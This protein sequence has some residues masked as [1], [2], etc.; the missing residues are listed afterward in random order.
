[1]TPRPNTSSA[2][3]K[4]LNATVQRT[5]VGAGASARVKSREC[6]GKRCSKTFKPGTVRRNRFWLRRS[7]R[8]NVTDK[9]QMKTP[10]S[11]KTAEWV[12]LSSAA[13]TPPSAKM[14]KMTKKLNDF[15][16]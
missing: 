5:T 16:R 1:M 12:F 13:K 8:K 9:R 11:R 3:N 2:P 4:M 15:K 14:E 10:I 7:I 6:G